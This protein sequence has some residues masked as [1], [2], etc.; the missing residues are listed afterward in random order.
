M[1]WLR[2]L[3][4]LMLATACLISALPACAQQTSEED[5]IILPEPAPAGVSMLLGDGSATE[6]SEATL[7][8]AAE[9]STT[10]SGV[11]RSIH[12][13]RGRTMVECVL[14]QLA[15]SRIAPPAAGSSVAEMS[16]ADCEE[17]RGIVTV[18]LT[19]GSYAQL[20]DQARLLRSIAIANTLLG[21]DGVEAVNLLYGDRSDS[22]AALP[23]GAFTQQYQGSTALYAQLQ[24]E[25]ESFLGSGSDAISRDVILYFPTSDGYFLPEKR[26]I[27]F[28]GSNYAAAL[29][30]TLKDKPEAL[31]CLSPIPASEDKLYDAPTLRIT[32]AGERVVVL[33]ISS[34]LLNYLAFSGM[35]PWQLYGSITLTLC[36]FIPELDGV[37]LWVD[38]VLV[39]DCTIG[40]RPTRF[41]DGAARRSDF[42]Q[43]IG[44]S[45]GMYFADEAGGLRRVERGM[46]QAD[47]ASPLGV[48]RAMVAAPAP[49][50][51][52]SVFP[53]EV[54][55][56]DIL[57]V[58]LEDGVASV[59][60]SGSFYT[61]CQSLSEG[62]ERCLIY[63]MVN[64]LCELSGVGA[65]RFLVE[66]MTLES[67]SQSIYLKTALLPDPGLVS[68]ATTTNQATDQAT[69]QAPME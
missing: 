60:L 67:L 3:L 36:S 49:E 22:I 31:D 48:L 52:R 33:N 53:E 15:D 43:R 54:Y 61:R 46:S 41:S 10:L 34:V 19:A 28:T 38:G 14:D 13:E 4:A 47:A 50:G 69:N 25:Q 40:D 26:N 30:D 5:A 39:T 42:S 23:T 58:Y 18:R 65:V 51:M 64:A 37:Q 57:G 29:L 35:E 17:S 16:L 62:Q 68:H 56:E 59:N 1:K 66:G 20:S 2:R 32:D 44:G 12:L 24:S 11:T 6:D 63:A 7:Y 55:G 45:A 8:F 9:G 21:I 27:R